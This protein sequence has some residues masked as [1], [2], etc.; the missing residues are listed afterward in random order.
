M[1]FLIIFSSLILLSTFVEQCRATGN[2]IADIYVDD[3][4]TNSSWYDAT[5]VHTIQE[6][7]NNATTG[8]TVFVYNGTYHENVTISKIINLIGENKS[9]TI[10]DGTGYEIVVTITS[11]NVNLSN[12]TVQNGNNYGIKINSFDYNSIFNCII[13][14][15][16]NG[17]YLLNSNWINISQNLIN[18]T[19]NIAINLV[20]TENC[21]IFDN[22]IKNNHCG[23]SFTLGSSN[24]IYHNNFINNDFSS[25]SGGFLW[26]N[27]YPSGGNYW[28]DYNG[29]DADGDGIGDT[30]YVDGEILDSYP[31]VFE[32]TIPPNFVWID[33]GFNDSTPGWGEDHFNCTQDGINALETNGAMYVFNGTYYENVEINKTLTIIGENKNT[34][35]INGSGAGHV[36]YISADWV[37]ISGFSIQNSET[38]Y[39]GISVY[40][41]YTN[42]TNNI[43]T[44]NSYGV[45]YTGS[46]N[47]T[48]LENTIANNNYGIYLYNSSHI[49]ISLN[50]V[51]S[52]ESALFVNI[53]NYN[54]LNK[55][56]METNDVSSIVLYF[57][58][59]NSL[60]GND[61]LKNGII[62]YGDEIDQYIHTIDNNT[63]NGKPLYYYKNSNKS[64]PADAGAVI[65]V[66]CTNATI[67][68]AN[69]ANVGAGIEIAYSHN[70]TVT[71]LSLTNS[72]LGIWSIYN[73][74]NT[75]HTNYI[76]NNTWGII[77]NYSNDN[78]I[79]NNYFNNTV[80]ALD[81]STNTWNTTKN[82]STNIINGTFIG[83]NYWSDYTGFDTDHDGLGDALYT[84]NDNITTGGDNY[85]LVISPNV[86]VNSCSPTEDSTSVSVSADITVIF[87]K[88]MNQTTTENNFLI[89]PLNDGEFNWINDYTLTFTPGSDLDYET[90][91]TVTIGW[92]A[93]DASGNVMLQNYIWSFTTEEST[94]GSSP[95]SGGGGGGYYIPPSGDTEDE[96]TDPPTADPS[97][98]YT[99]LTYQ[100]IR[101]DGSGSTDN[102]TIIDYQWTFGDGTMGWGIK[103]THIYNR[104]G[105]F[106]VTLTVTDNTNLTDTEN[107]TV[108]IKL[109]TDG[110]G[111]S[112]E[113]EE[114]YNSDK[115]NANDIPLDTDNDG[116]LDADDEDDDNDIIN[117][118]IETILGTNPKIK[119]ITIKVLNGIVFYLI[120]LDDDGIPDRFYNASSEKDVTVKIRED[121]TYL[122]NID[123][124]A[125]WDYV[126]D[127]ASGETTNYEEKPGSSDGLPWF[128][129]ASV[130]IIIIIAIIVMLYLFGYI[131]IGEE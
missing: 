67:A 97:G 52:I 108:N 98:P 119:D 47:N 53:S 35:V 55:N 111:W 16:L 23:I 57:S 85:P 89:D 38:D 113:D 3:N 14:N 1:I 43:I 33:V 99:A 71:N 88:S 48:L 11:N 4:A 84:S 120:D 26:D 122:L 127:P 78:L 105:V 125:Y 114:Y 19:D 56:S 63:A 51:N 24:M 39:T 41:N 73:D 32:R 28:D 95:P 93:T 61:F 15:N 45:Y 124:D 68:D 49:N 128:T 40:S 77:L 12:L 31:L 80:N 70:I 76:Y 102:G 117:D 34:T 91:Y 10:I 54:Y 50:D 121:G 92:N 130:I 8:D 25:G 116:V 22:N 82:S 104:S 109:D 27:G 46:S 112:D 42:V 65:L 20:Q 5:H 81:D 87:D 21:S 101:F 74:N 90:P 29:I 86:L 36:V 131:W 107:T 115:T 18:N 62:I 2:T 100:S 44:N 37:N 69:I 13:D 129:I 103:P 64:V 96:L 58:I 59:N 60:I 106:V 126:Y 94:G 83:G 7:I 79:Y 110:D 9:S 6:G 17:I 72:V 30:P 118:E 75:I 123:S 66:N